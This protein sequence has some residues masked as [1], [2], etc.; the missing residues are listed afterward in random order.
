MAVMKIFSRSK[1]R[2]NKLEKDVEELKRMVGIKCR[3]TR[4][5]YPKKG[6]LQKRMGDLEET[7]GQVVKIINKRVERV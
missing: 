3:D 1:D 4:V 2:I 6:T 7:V 5:I